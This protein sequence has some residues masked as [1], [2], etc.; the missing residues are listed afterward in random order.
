MFRIVR[1]TFA[2]SATAVGLGAAFGCASRPRAP[3]VRPVAEAPRPASP[4]L[5]VPRGDIT[6]GKLAAWRRSDAEWARWSD[7]STHRVLFIPV[8]GRAIGDKA[9]PVRVEVL[10]WG[11]SGAAVVLL[12]GAGGT[13][14]IYDDLAPQLAKSFRVV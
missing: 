6:P 3:A 7:P 10:D 11:G 9:Q 8:A 1:V 12:A 14:H 4:M 2:A 13:A 5:G